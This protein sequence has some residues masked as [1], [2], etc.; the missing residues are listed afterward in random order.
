MMTVCR[1][2]SRLVRQCRSE[3]G[4]ELVEFAFVLPV[5]LLLIAAIADF[6]LLFQSYEVATNAAREGARLAVLPGYTVND[7]AT[8]RTRVASYL[9]AGGAAGTFQTDVAPVTLNLGAGLA[10]SGV[11]VTVTYTHPFLFIGPI[12]GLINGT[13]VNTLTYQTTA[14]M[15]TEIQVPVPAGGP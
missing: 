3:S 4:A 10:G 5:L 8:V 15:R 7:Y 6:A 1:T 11:Q 9:A 13:F 14:Q 2:R 12:V